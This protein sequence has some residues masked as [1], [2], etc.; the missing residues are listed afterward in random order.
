MDL[1]VEEIGGGCK[2]AR[3]DALMIYNVSQTPGMSSNSAMIFFTL[4]WLLA[5]SQAKNNKI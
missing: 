1:T 2:E 3:G 4:I 5:S